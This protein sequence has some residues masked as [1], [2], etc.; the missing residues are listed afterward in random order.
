M[1][2]EKLSAPP[3]FRFSLVLFCP[4]VVPYESGSC[5]FRMGG[6]PFAF[7]PALGFLLD[8]SGWRK[9]RP[10]ASPPQACVCLAVRALGRLGAV[11][12]WSCRLRGRSP[13]V[14]DAA[15]TLAEKERD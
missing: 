7:W 14:S 13:E 6:F 12:L 5:R 15:Q 3:G 8:G 4:L 1:D 11:F 2:S 9:L 10:R